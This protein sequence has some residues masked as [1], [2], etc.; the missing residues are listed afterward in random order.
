ML[1]ITQINQDL[2]WKDISG[3]KERTYLFPNKIESM[4]DYP[5]IEVTV[6]YPI[7][8]NV[9]YTSGGHKIIDEWGKSWYIP[10]G[11]VGLNWISH[12][13]GV[14]TYKF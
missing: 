3:E 4:Y 1:D 11:W 13:D 10:T 8:F 6:R 7:L 2:E 5:L 12:I 9:N 14:P